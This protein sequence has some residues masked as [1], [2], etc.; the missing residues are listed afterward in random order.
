MSDFSFRLCGLIARQ[1]LRIGLRNR[2][3]PVYAVVFAVL[4]GAVSYFGLSVIE[5]TGF[6]GFERTTVS[7]LNLVLYIVPLAAMLMTVQSF[8]SEGGAT[9]QLFTEPV[10]R[11]EIVAGK[12]AGVAGAITLAT[13]LGFGLPA[14]LIARYAGTG[15]LGSYLI[16]VAYTVLLATVFCSIA[17]LVTIAMRRSLRAYAA[18]LTVWFVLLLLY[19]LV[20]I[21]I[22]F[23]L[24]EGYANR[25]AIWCMFFN[26]VD[27]TR[28][29]TL[30]ATAG[31]E[32]YGLAG[33]LL[34][35]RLHGETR[36]I[37][38]LTLAICAW[39]Y[40]PARYAARILRRQDI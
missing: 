5:F 27:S 8:S 22:T 36:A 40:F 6:Q 17:A 14:A 21:G 20:V 1:E 19:D 7:L 35:R 15:G 38:T 29:A 13:L 18:V 30:M 32:V 28:V 3:V 31:K 9:D 12:L 34:T 23:L 25:T 37:I 39:A 33:A 26:P 2:W 10:S 16:L 4:T 24:P 11:S